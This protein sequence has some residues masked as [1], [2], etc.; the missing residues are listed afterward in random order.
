MDFV[1]WCGHVLKKLIEAGRDPHINEIKLAQLLYGEEFRTAGDFHNSTHRHG[2]LDA[3]NE[4]R[5]LGL[6]EERSGSFWTVTPEGR[7]FDADP[8]PLWQ[9]LCSVTLEPDEERILKVI[10]AL[11]SKVGSDPPHAWLEKVNRE[12]LLKEYG[13]TAGMDMLKVLWPVS[14]DLERRRLVYRDARAG[15]HLNLK[16]TYA[17][18]VWETRRAHLRKCDVF[19]SHATDE[20]AIAMELK[21]FLTTAFG[22]DLKVFVSSD[23][24]SIR[25][26]K[27]WFDELVEALRTAPVV[28]TLLT[29]Y[30][31]GRRWI[32]FESGIGYGAGALVIPLTTSG[33]AKSAV[34]PPLSIL[35]ARSL[36]DGEDVLGAI[37]DIAEHLRREA[38]KKDVDSF[39]TAMSE[40]PVGTPDKPFPLEVHLEPI[41]T[42]PSDQADIY[43]LNV[44]L[45]NT[46]SKV[47]NDYIVEIEFPIDFAQTNSTLEVPEMV[48]ATH[49]FFRVTEKEGGAKPLHAGDK[50]RVM[51][52]D[53]TIDYFKVRDVRTDDKMREVVIIKVR[54]G[55]ASPSVVR[56]ELVELV[57]AP[58]S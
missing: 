36:N 5:N 37:D 29:N 32:N 1:D 27:K 23:Y 19:I 13:I 48:T 2:M 58:E 22:E 20:R 45:E 30:S 16:P 55:D 31:V 18:L 56:H 15:F 54:T 10:N 25:G 50:R 33:F 43:R 35:Q 44:S 53:Y 14:E 39:I 49:R 38:V 12:P 17:S 57:Q 42:F 26:G 8:T 28:L 46:G 21:G 41:L 47:I 24:R 34:G 3:V 6:L 51:S 4:L 11:G 7:A 9:G 40:L 52:L